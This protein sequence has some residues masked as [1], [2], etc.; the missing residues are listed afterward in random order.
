MRG[1]AALLI[2]ALALGACAA[3]GAAPPQATA[4]GEAALPPAEEKFS[5][6]PAREPAP[7]DEAAEAPPGAAALIGLSPE[8]VTAVLGKA[9]LARADGP[10]RVLQFANGQCVLDV[11]FYDGGASFLAA[12]ST[13]GEAVSA[14]FC[15]AALLPG[16]TLTAQ[17]SE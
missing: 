8:A 15:Y 2:A 16:G 17:G 10:A 1:T 7:A 3:P 13:A 5:A 11:F 4:K 14:E 9:S 12:R 6:E